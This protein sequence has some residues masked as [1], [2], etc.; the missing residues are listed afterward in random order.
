MLLQFGA[1]EM[2]EK[3]L[4]P[5]CFYGKEQSD[6]KF[7]KGIIRR[8]WE[9]ERI[10]FLFLFIQIQNMC[11]TVLHTENTTTTNVSNR[12]IIPRDTNIKLTATNWWWTEYEKSVSFLFHT[13]RRP[14]IYFMTTIEHFSY[15]TIVYLG[16]QLF[17]ITTFRFLKHF[18][19]SKI[20]FV[21]YAKSIW[22]LNRFVK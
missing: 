6:L 10:F 5:I 22:P 20:R 15:Q 1:R 13:K 9:R 16:F 4:E 18:F 2:R 14:K 21:S 11:L 12:V 17:T 19:K 3:N 7:Q 8:T